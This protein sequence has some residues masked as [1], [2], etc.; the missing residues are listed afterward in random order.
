MHILV[1]NDDGVNAPGLL[2]LT[3]EMRK[4]GKVTVFAPDKNWSASGHVKT[5]ERPLRVK[6]VMLADGTS[7]YASDG[8]PSDCVALPLLGLVEEPIDIV[9]SGINPNANIGHDV[10]YSGTVTA[11]MEGV[12]AGV[13]G[14]AVSLDSPEGH[15]A[16]LDYSTA[17]AV[18]RRV[19]EQVIADGLPEGV[20]LNV[21]V[22][23]LPEAELKGYMITRQGLRVYRDALDVRTDPRGK[24]YYWIG[25]EAPTGVDEPGTDF[26][27]LRAGYVSITPL[28]LDLTHVKAMDVLKKWNF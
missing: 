11:A 16:P 15:R 22:P 21:N 1:T 7:A 20:V 26:G 6:E 14:V 18:G 28:Q 5:M 13:K 3:Q 10:T 9:V 2:A 8:A 24:P 17:A 12:I 19:V 23:Y 25:G 27:A 4:L